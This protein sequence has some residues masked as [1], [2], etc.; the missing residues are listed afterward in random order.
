MS[1]S[2]EESLSSDRE[3]ERLK[4]EVARL[5]EELANLRRQVDGRG[6]PPDAAGAQQNVAHLRSA[7]QKLHES[8]QRFREL[9]DLLPASISFT[10]KSDHVFLE[11]NRGFEEGSGPRL[12]SNP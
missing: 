12:G 7:E 2:A 8:E 6:L 1:D 4:R 10:R 5:Q 3:I 11:V 9:F